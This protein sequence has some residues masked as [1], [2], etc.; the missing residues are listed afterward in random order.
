MGAMAAESTEAGSR[1]V[2]PLES[3]AGGFRYRGRFA[4]YLFGLARLDLYPDRL[5]FGPSSRLVRNFVPVWEVQY[6]SLEL[7]IVRRG[8][9]GGIGFKSSD[10]GTFFFTPQPK[11]LLDDAIERVV[12][13]LRRVGVTV[14]EPS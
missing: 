5:R 2:S 13:A 4:H 8:F 12:V 11:G 7:V 6:T 14:A 3:F 9:R 1:G 10:G